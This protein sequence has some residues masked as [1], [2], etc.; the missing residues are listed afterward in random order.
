MWLVAHCVIDAYG[1]R[2][3]SLFPTEIQPSLNKQTNSVSWVCEQ[4]I[5]AE[6]PPLVGE[7]SANFC[8]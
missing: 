4:T 7:V 8:G 3:P 5:L 6:W 2:N 1:Q